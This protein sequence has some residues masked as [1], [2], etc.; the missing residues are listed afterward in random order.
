MSDWRIAMRTDFLTTDSP[1]A[2]LIWERIGIARGIDQKGQMQDAN[3]AMNGAEQIGVA[4][5][6]PALIKLCL[7]ENYRRMAGYDGRLL[8]P[9]AVPMLARFALRLFRISP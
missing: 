4:I 1:S 2:F 5:D 7:A 9:A 6:P 8:R 3:F